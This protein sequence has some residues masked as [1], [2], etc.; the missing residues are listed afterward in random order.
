FSLYMKLLEETITSIREGKTPKLDDISNQSCEIKLN[1]A[2]LIPDSYLN[3]PH[4]RLL[5]YKRISNA[6]SD[7]E[8]SELK[9]EMINRFGLLT[10][11]INQLFSVTT[12]KLR[13]IQLG[14]KK[15]SSSARS[16]NAS[17]SNS[18]PFDAVKLI[19]L[20]QKEPTRYQFKGSQQ[21]SVHINAESP[22]ERVSAAED[23]LSTLE[24]L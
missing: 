24:A 12:I 19:E 17:F 7:Q 14:I 18:I 5:L 8:L 15:L 1:I 22:E 4:N 16:L 6:S 23:F 2:A 20:V 9:I 10:P 21:I 11:E 3:D 13:A